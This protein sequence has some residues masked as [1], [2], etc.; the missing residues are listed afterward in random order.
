MWSA[1]VALLSSLGRELF[2]LAREALLPAPASP[3]GAIPDSTAAAL[4]NS[5]A[6]AGTTGVVYLDDFFKMPPG[7]AG[8]GKS[9]AVRAGS[10]GK[11]GKDWPRFCSMRSR[12]RPRLLLRLLLLLRRGRYRL[13]LLGKLT[14]TG[15]ECALT[16]IADSLSCSWM[17]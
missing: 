17:R 14:S 2:E 5:T 12:S 4:P 7:F 16:S 6:A 1:D 10:G 9:A 13:S 3:P 15:R 11:G 8:D